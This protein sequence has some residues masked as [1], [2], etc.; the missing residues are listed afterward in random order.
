MREFFQQI[1]RTKLGLAGAV[2]TTAS[3]FLV[4]FF[5]VLSVAGLEESPYVGVLAYLVL[6][7]V[8]VVGL[9]LIPFALWLERR[10]LRQAGPQPLPVLDLNQR[11]TRGRVLLFATLTVANVLILAAASWKGVEVMDRPAFCGSCHSVM[12]D[13]K[14]VV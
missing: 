4:A 14:S 11:T 5:V 3:G 12:E 6:P 7:A 1:I 8:F 9:L 13:R 2:L 10:R